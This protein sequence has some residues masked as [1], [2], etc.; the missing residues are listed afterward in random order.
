MSPEAITIAWLSDSLARG[1]HVTE[2][3]MEAARVVAASCDHED[4]AVITTLLMTI[5]M[6]DAGREVA[7][8]TVRTPEEQ[9]RLDVATKVAAAPDPYPRRSR[10]IRRAIAD[11]WAEREGGTMADRD[12]TRRVMRTATPEDRAYVGVLRG[13]R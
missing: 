13:Q 1:E 6:V 9:R 5:A 10:A 7:P 4:A 12:E 8:L 3:D 11:A 2:A